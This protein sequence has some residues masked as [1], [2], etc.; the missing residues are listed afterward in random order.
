M[1]DD[2]NIVTRV[3]Q[4]KPFGQ[5]DV[6]A[7]EDTPETAEIVDFAAARHSARATA[8][9]GGKNGGKPPS[10]GK[11]DGQGPPEVAPPNDDD[12]D[13]GMIGRMND[14]WAFCILGSRAVIM[15]ERIDGPIEDRLKFLSIDAFR[16]YY[17][18][19]KVRVTREVR[20]EDGELEKK[21]VY[22][23]RATWWLKHRLRRTYDGIEFFPNP[24]GAA[25]T[26]RY[27]NLWRG[28]SVVP[29]PDSECAPA[30]RWKKYKT[31]RDHILTNICRGNED[32]FKWLFAW[33]AHIVQKPRERPGT[34]VVMRGLMGTGKTIVGQ[35]LGS[36]F[37]AHYFLV[38]DARYVT[39]QFNAHMASCILL[40][41]D[42]AGWAGDK[43][44][45]G[46][47]KGLITAPKQMIEAKGVD[48]IRI[49][50]HVRLMM[51]SNNDWIVPA[52]MDERRFAVFDVAD[53]VK[54][55]RDYFAELIAELDNG[56]RRAFLADL[57]S[58]DLAGAPD[59]HVVP[60]TEA[61][62]EQKV[63]SFDPV[64]SWLYQRLMDGAMTRRA[65]QWKSSVPIKTVY[66]DYNR[67]AEKIGVRRRQ[68]EVNF[69]LH[70]RRI[71][72]GI[73]RKKH[74]EDVEVENEDGSISFV[75]RRVWC[76][77]MPDL[78]ECR[79]AF[80]SAIYQTVEWGADD[81]DTGDAGTQG[82]EPL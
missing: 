10:R 46:R 73:T 36:L 8:E 41:A 33:M 69:A 62:L 47:L 82:D 2:D 9:G 61:L 3:E 66:N 19:A 40:Q 35:V 58:L 51:S 17:Q 7:A 27:L 6:A 53:N 4:A 44:A 72:P 60:K 78:A 42:E 18:N 14:E 77:E 12:D 20:N 52:G 57:L 79:A 45:E 64:T 54:E 76:W 22:F 55:N 39:G 75:R 26:P 23:Q 71:L 25:A 5:D 38:D 13:G 29:M 48:P 67:S 21:H 74:F 32:H 65:S 49:D 59:V 11:E 80:E 43:S 37:E 56:G 30:E 1:N 81:D 63:Q 15:R 70:V 50:N 24:D 28:F 16:A 34:A 68:E 31:F